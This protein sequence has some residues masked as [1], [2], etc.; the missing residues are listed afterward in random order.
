MPYTQTI[1]ATAFSLIFIL[2]TLG[3]N[4]SVYSSSDLNTL[5]NKDT[6]L[7]KTL[8]PED[9]RFI[10]SNF[11]VSYFTESDDI[12]REFLY[13]GFSARGGCI[14]ALVLVVGMF[15]I[16]IVSDKIDT[17]MLAAKYV[18][19]SWIHQGD[20]QTFMIGVI[21]QLMFTG[22]LLSLILTILCILSALSHQTYVPSVGID[23]NREDY[24][25]RELSD[26][27]SN[28]SDNVVHRSDFL[29]V[30][31]FFSAGCLISVYFVD[32]SLRYDKK[33]SM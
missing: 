28:S 12:A 26:E 1:V 22:A 18:D 9:C 19:G 32:Y 2:I 14:S 23:F 6:Y 30:S 29:K 5:L 4:E 21:Y 11:S 10:T 8:A 3:F 20:T 24:N 16:A 17:D 33:A 27:C 7:N 13:G 31:L 25:P 15:V